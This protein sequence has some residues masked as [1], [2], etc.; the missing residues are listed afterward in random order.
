MKNKHFLLILLTIV[1]IGFGAA[2]VVRVNRP[3]VKLEDL[4]NNNEI[5]VMAGDGVDRALESTLPGYDPSLE[6]LSVEFTDALAKTQLAVLATY[7]GESNITDIATYYNLH[8]DKVIKGEINSEQITFINKIRLNE[9]NGR[10]EFYPE[11]SIGFLK[12]GEQYLLCLK[13]LNNEFNVRLP[14]KMEEP[15]L[16]NTGSVFDFYQVSGDEQQSIYMGFSEDK[17]FRMTDIAEDTQV[18][19]HTSDNLNIY[20]EQRDKAKRFIER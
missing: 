12:K 1:L 8:L 11:E 17:L 10:K 9:L 13:P 20:N 16:L 18:F 7:T 3:E 19:V 14:E 15:Y 4:K 6:V 2:I 5:I